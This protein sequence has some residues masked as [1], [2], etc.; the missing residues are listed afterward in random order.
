MKVVK[1][2]VAS[3]Y[4]RMYRGRI[5]YNPGRNQYDWFDLY[6]ANDKVIAI[7]HIA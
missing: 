1:M 6:N 2:N 7:T 5:S 4:V 3:R